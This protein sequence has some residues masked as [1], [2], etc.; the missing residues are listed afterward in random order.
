MGI[1]PEQNLE[2]TPREGQSNLK[3]SQLKQEKAHGQVIFTAQDSTASYYHR[4]PLINRNLRTPFQVMIYFNME[5][6]LCNPEL[7]LC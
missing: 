3:N 4:I 2:I 5:G 1:L 6:W 7:C